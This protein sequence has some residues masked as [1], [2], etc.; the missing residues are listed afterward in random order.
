M[1]DLSIIVIAIAL[2]MD[3]FAVS[4]AGG[5]SLKCFHWRAFL[6]TSL[7]M[8]LFQAIFFSAGY[9]L[10]SFVNQWVQTWDHWIAFGILA[11]VG[12]HMIL[13]HFQENK[14]QVIDLKRK[15]V[16]LALAVATS[17][18]AL[19]VGIG[20]SILD[21]HYWRMISTIGIV[22][23]V[24][25]GAGVILGCFVAKVK[26]FPAHLIGG[27]ILV[28]IGVKILIDHLINHI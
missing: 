27:I 20:F 21:F 26:C 12:G 1:N 10:A 4:L 24:L 17:I 13:E 5:V 25:S 6:F 8:G 16:V 3:S 23:F 15:R 2:A 9:F 18:D 22:S 11:F 19:A 7:A 28:G 14:P